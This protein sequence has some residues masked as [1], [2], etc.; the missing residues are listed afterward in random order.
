MQEITY[1]DIIRH[2]Q[3]KIGE[4]SEELEKMQRMISKVN[5]DFEDAW[6]GVNA[7]IFREKLYEVGE[8]VRRTEDC[9]EEVQKKLYME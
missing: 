5:H 4:I 2:Y 6:S 7:D 9:L 8:R 3:L 1:E